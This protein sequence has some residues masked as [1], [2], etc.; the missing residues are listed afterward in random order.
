MVD[1]ARLNS[2]T[3]YPSIDT[4]H[5]LDPKNGM[6][7]EQWTH[8]AGEVILTEKVDGTNGRI[9]VMPDGDFYIGSRE[10]L[11]HARGD[12]VWATQLGIVDCLYELAYS[13]NLPSA[14]PGYIRTYYLEVYGGGIGQSYK[15]YT[16]SKTTTG[17]RLFDTSL[18][19]TE[20]LD[21]DRGRIASWREHGGQQWADESLLDQVSTI[22]DVPLT[23]RLGTV[24]AGDLPTDLAGTAHWLGTTLPKTLTALDDSAQGRPEGIVL[25][26]ADRTV[27]AKARVQDYQRTLRRLEEAQR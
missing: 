4:Y 16:T 27:I 25:R 8:F 24:N 13:G 9:I 10:E 22:T 14:G 19:S 18:V 21:L 5:T 12:R 7:L 15:N 23:P 2:A 20:I 17:Y 1:L 6:L 11:F 26:S 3:K